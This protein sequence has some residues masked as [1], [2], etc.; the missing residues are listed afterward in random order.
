MAAN[1]RSG[2]VAAAAEYGN[3]DVKGASELIQSGASIYAD[4]RTPE[5][6]AAGHPPGAVNVPVFL[7][8][9]GQM[10]PN[11]QF[12]QQFEKAFPDKDAQLCAAGY[13]NLTNVEGGYQAWTGA[14]L[15]VE[16]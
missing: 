9:N 8:Q 2:S 5:E 3:T 15:P 10:V 12:Q 14:G 11:P 7:K 1:F 4:V 6:F 16:A 13:S